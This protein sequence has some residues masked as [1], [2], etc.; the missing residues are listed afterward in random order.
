MKIQTLIDPAR[1]HLDVQASSLED[2][3]TTV[4]DL[5]AVG[6]KVTSEVVARGL[7]EREELGSTAIGGGFAIPHCKLRGVSGIAI[8]LAR[9][10]EAVAFGSSEEETVRFVFVVL[11]PPDQPALHLQALSHIARTLKS[12]NIR[13]QLLEVD[14][15][16]EIVDV[17]KLATDGG[18]L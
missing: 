16:A 4:S 6:L 8:T 15:P 11:S 17:V 1:V 13:R 7:L 2:A 3:L 18:R 10:R 12:E 9:F 14:D 5:A